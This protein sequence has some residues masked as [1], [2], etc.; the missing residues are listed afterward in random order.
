MNKLKIAHHLKT[1]LPSEDFILTGT[2]ALSQLGFVKWI[3]DL[4]GIGLKDGKDIADK[5][6]QA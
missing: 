1:V 5:L 4:L 6:W 3:K 2:F